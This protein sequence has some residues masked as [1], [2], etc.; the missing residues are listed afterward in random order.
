M[1]QRSFIAPLYIAGGLLL[2]CASEPQP[3][4]Q[5]QWYPIPGASVAPWEQAQG[6]CGPILKRGQAAII[7]GGG[8]YA[9]IQA[10]TQYESCMA[11]YGW[12]ERANPPVDEA[13]STTAR[14]EGDKF[15]AQVQ[16]S[17]TKN[18][19]TLLVGASPDCQAGDPGTEI[20]SWRWNWHSEAL[21]QTVPL[22]MTCVLP[23]A[24]GPR[25]ENSCRVNAAR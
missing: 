25:E 15:R 23:Q 17:R 18:E 14:Q 8:V 5:T 20:C 12:T 19:L 9:A 6:S 22:E 1:Y 7:M 3:Q 16:A 13:R 10:K 4:P 11:Q 24:G 2:A 21:S